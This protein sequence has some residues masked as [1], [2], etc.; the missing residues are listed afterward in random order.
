M[1]PG[2]DRLGPRLAPVQWRGPCVG[3]K[4]GE[5][6]PCHAGFQSLVAVQKVEP[7]D[8]LYAVLGMCLDS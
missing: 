6:M 2:R 4:I 7:I 3:S 8:K 1:A 5:E